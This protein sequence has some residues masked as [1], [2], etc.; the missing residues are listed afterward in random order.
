M[1]SLFSSCQIVYINDTKCVTIT[2]M[3]KFILH[4]INVIEPIGTIKMADL[5]TSLNIPINGCFSFGEFPRRRKV[6]IIADNN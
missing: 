3:M 5:K 1:I 2:K 4:M 6:I